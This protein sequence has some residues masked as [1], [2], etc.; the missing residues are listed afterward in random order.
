MIHAAVSQ[1]SLGLSGTT[2]H[3]LPTP[4]GQISVAMVLTDSSTDLCDC[5]MLRMKV[6]HTEG[7][8]LQVDPIQ[9]SGL[10]W[11]D[12]TYQQI[13]E[14]CTTQ[15]EEG[16]Y[17]SMIFNHFCFV[18]FCTIYYCTVL[19]IFLLLLPIIQICHIWLFLVPFHLWWH[20]TDADLI[21]LTPFSVTH[22]KKLPVASGC[23]L[24][25]SGPILS[26]MR[27]IQSGAWNR[28][29]AWASTSGLLVLG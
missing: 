13:Q 25:T 22:A 9:C 12:A 10:S 5:D 14:V 4:C 20:R 18:L 19:T 6:V 1:I 8:L 16:D 27:R 11:H 17:K 24:P 28:V 3:K 7:S 2:I 15:A 23:A 26:N 29:A 21:L